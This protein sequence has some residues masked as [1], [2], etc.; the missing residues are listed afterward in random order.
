[1]DHFEV[2]KISR[3]GSY[4]Y[5]SVFQPKN[6]KERERDSKNIEVSSARTLKDFL[7]ESKHN[8]FDTFVA[9]SAPWFW[10]CFGTTDLAE[11]R[12]YGMVCIII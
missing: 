7:L 9:D 6:K 5:I 12:M 2:I 4:A 3:R 8:G 11:P 1:M 10:F